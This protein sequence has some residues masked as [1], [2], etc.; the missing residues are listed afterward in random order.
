M[1]EG[2]AEF[3]QTVN[4][5]FHPIYI[6]KPWIYITKERGNVFVDFLI[7]LRLFSCR[8]LTEEEASLTNTAVKTVS[9]PKDV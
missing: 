5:S 7:L 9:L 6:R 4:N 8:D 2:M 1:D 3:L